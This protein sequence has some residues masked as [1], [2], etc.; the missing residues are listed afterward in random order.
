MKLSRNSFELPTRLPKGEDTGVMV[1]TEIAALQL[2]SAAIVFIPGEP[3]A[4]TALAIRQA[5]VFELTAVV[6]F[7]EE[8]IGYI[9]T[10][11]AFVEGG[12]EAGFGKWSFLSPGSE[13]H[14]QREALLLLENL[15]TGVEELS[16]PDL[17]A[18]Q[19][20]SEG[21]AAHASEELRASMARGGMR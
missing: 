11:Q 21:A 16:S 5:S 15:V 7:S 4:E 1:R 19:V 18:A 3:F 10:N 14:V 13:V 9:P 2:G 6:G 8:T 12:Y 17:A 20:S